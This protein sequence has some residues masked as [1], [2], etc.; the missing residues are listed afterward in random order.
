MVIDGKI[1]TTNGLYVV[2]HKAQHETTLRLYGILNL[3]FG[4]TIEVMV[5]SDIGIDY[6]GYLVIG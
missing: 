6:L 3:R 2:E 1:D 4:Q 5:K